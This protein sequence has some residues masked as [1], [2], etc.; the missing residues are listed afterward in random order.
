MS[1]RILTHAHSER[2]LIVEW[3]GNSYCQCVAKKVDNVDSRW[4]ITRFFGDP[5][6]RLCFWWNMSAAQH[7]FVQ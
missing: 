3:S 5:T 6:P 4:F 1:Q 2:F 7:N